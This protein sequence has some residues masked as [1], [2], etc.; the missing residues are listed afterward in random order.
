MCVLPFLVVFRITPKSFSSFNFF[1][2]RFKEPDSEESGLSNQ[3]LLTLSCENVAKP[4][5]FQPTE[6]NGEPFFLSTDSLWNN[7]LELYP[8]LP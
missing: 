2:N 8:F 3:S 6:N 7:R 5:L 1:R 4:S